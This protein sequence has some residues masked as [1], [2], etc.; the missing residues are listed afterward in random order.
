MSF[1]QK[2]NLQEETAATVSPK[3]KTSEITLTDF[4]KFRRVFR[5][6]FIKENGTTVEMN[7]KVTREKTIFTI[8]YFYEDKTITSYLPTAMLF[9]P[10]Y[11]DIP[12]KLFTILEDKYEMEQSITTKKLS[13]LDYMFLNAN[14]FVFMYAKYIF[15]KMQKNEKHI[16]PQTKHFFKVL[17]DDEDFLEIVKIYDTKDESFDHGLTKDHIEEVNSVLGDE[18]DEPEE[19][20]NVEKQT[21]PKNIRKR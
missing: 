8:K 2:F 19:V 5:R 11:K 16:T 15:D 4:G 10:K 3:Y 20:N 14:R 12:D 21:K 6:S 7:T 18:E 17:F 1:Q 13:I 9:E